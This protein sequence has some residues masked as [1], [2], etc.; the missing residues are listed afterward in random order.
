M[1]T[2]HPE[3]IAEWR[4]ALKYLLGLANRARESRDSHLSDARTA[5]ETLAS[6]EGRMADLRHLLRQVDEDNP[7]YAD[8]E[9][10]PVD[11]RVRCLTAWR[12]ML[13]FLE[14]HPQLPI[15][16]Y[17]L[18]H[19]RDDDEVS[20]DQVEAAAQLFGEQVRSYQYKHERR[21]YVEKWFG[22]Q[23]VGLKV[24]A[25]LPAEPE[26]LPEAAELEAVDDTATQ[27]AQQ[28]LDAEQAGAA[29][30][31]PPTPPCGCEAGESCPDCV[32]AAADAD[33]AQAE[34]ALDAY[35]AAYP[36]DGEDGGA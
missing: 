4:N 26:P 1:R 34:R 10:D 23:T 5:A 18:I 33:E 36:T 12:E 15:P 17:E 7:E 28:L 24:A 27:D 11:E 14:A 9:P 16:T 8:P 31:L 35:M 2:Y 21:V 13:D 6:Y 22:A 20:A 19:L 32:P 25:T 3:T 29:G 30:T